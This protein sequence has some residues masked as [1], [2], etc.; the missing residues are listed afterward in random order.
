MS[1]DFVVF[2]VI[3][4]V[5]NMVHMHHLT[6]SMALILLP[7]QEVHLLEQL[8]L[9]VFELSNHIGLLLVISVVPNGLKID[10]FHHRAGVHG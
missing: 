4:S 9:V 2:G 10:F 5:L 6:I 7:V 1:T 8:L 3:L